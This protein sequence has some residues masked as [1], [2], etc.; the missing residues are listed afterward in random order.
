VFLKLVLT[1]EKRGTRWFLSNN[2]WV[3][4][5]LGSSQARWGQSL[6]Q[7]AIS[8]KCNIKFLWVL[9]LPCLNRIAVL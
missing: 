3:G 4:Q 2:Q 8:L 7:S 5:G 1:Y 9:N 6:H